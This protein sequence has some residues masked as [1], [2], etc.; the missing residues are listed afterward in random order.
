MVDYLL[1]LY[2]GEDLFI[3]VVECG[4]LLFEGV[5]VWLCWIVWSFVIVNGLEAENV[6]C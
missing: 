4:Q 2:G 3:S 1:L 5:C 6:L